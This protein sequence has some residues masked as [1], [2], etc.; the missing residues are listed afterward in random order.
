MASEFLK[1]RS[2]VGSSSQVP[3]VTCM[4]PSSSRLPGCA[5]KRCPLHWIFREWPWS[6]PSQNVQMCLHA[7]FT[8]LEGLVLS[9]SG[10]RGTLCH[11]RVTH[12]R[13]LRSVSQKALLL[14]GAPQLASLEDKAT[15][16]AKAKACLSSSCSCTWGKRQAE[17]FYQLK[18]L[19]LTLMLLNELL[20]SIY[21]FLFEMHRISSN[22]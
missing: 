18:A 19:F 16:C 9:T 6:G 1:P 15:P 13:T 20:P 10:R 4:F 3:L 11:W 2:R 21:L 7:G 8:S 12:A 22:C 5:G 14:T 17:G